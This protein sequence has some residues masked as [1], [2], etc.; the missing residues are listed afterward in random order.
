MIIARLR[1][2]P[3][4][5]YLIGAGLLWGTIGIC[6]RMIFERSDLDPFEI[7]WLRTLFAMPGC[8]GLGLHQGGRRL[9]HV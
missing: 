1:M 6:G 2:R 9:F 8:L 3:G 7:S 5:V 4:L